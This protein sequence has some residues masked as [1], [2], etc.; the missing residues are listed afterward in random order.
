MESESELSVRLCDGFFPEMQM[1]WERRHPCLHDLNGERT[2]EKRK[3]GKDA[4]VA[5]F[6]GP[7][8]SFESFP[9][10]TR[11]CNRRIS[12]VDLSCANPAR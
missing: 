9:Q 12:P 4:C 10:G 8:D 1:V 2:L 7:R 6:S 3:A 11:K 5:G